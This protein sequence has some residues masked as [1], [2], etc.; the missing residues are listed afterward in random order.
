M[1]VS[2]FTLIRNGTRFDYPYIESLRSLLPLVDE[3]VINVGIGDDDTAQK[4]AELAR[5]EGGGKIVTFESRWPLDDPEKK[6]AGLILSE[7]TNLALDKCRGDWCVYLQADEVFHE[8][9]AEALRQAMRSAD[10]RPEV[11]GLLFDYVHFYG[12]FDVVQQTRSA[13]RREVRAFKRA[14]G[15]RSVGDAQS[16]RKLDGSKLRVTRSGARVFHYGWVRTPEAMREKTFFMDQL[17]HGDPDKK[18]AAEM[19][20]HTGDNY[21]Y[22]RFW[23]LR[24]FQGTHPAVMKERIRAK[25]WHWDL[26]RS[27]FA[28]EWSD[29]KKVLLDLVERATGVRLFEYRSYRR[30]D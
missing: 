20:P 9:D 10:Q 7:Q 1:K 5:N 24:P 19:L 22:K 29:S 8:A 2:G 16:F 12:S 26:A 27:P 18:A 13:Y 21:R 15:A 25:G 30:V 14:S 6:K 3:L 4:I 28:W 17:Y 23:G 11:D